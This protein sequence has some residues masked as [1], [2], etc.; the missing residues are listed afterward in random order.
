MPTVSRRTRS[1]RCRPECA[2]EPR[3]CGERSNRHAQTSDDQSVWPRAS[4]EQSLRCG[5]VLLCREV[6]NRGL[7]VAKDP[8]SFAERF[9]NPLGAL[10]HR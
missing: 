4:V 6:P 10:P 8:L 9:P 2:T 7:L 5:K 1:A 3:D